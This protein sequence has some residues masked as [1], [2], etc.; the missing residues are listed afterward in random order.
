[1]GLRLQRCRLMRLLEIGTQAVQESEEQGDAHQVAHE[2]SQ[3][4]PVSAI[5]Q[6]PAVI[7]TGSEE[8]AGMCGQGIVGADEAC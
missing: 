1:M 2:D 4:A 3:A 7:E 5:A 8:K 6:V